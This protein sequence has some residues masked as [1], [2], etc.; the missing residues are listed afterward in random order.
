MSRSFTLSGFGSSADGNTALTIANSVV[1]SN[2]TSNVI[3]N[4]LSVAIGNSSVF[5][6]INATSYNG[7]ANNSLYLGGTAAASYVTTSTIGGLTANNTAYLGGLAASGY[8]T[9]AGLSA[10]VAT[11]AANNASYLGGVAAAS[12][13]NTSG[14]YTFTGIHSHNVGG[15]TIYMANTTSN[16]ISWGTGGVAAPAVTTKSAGTK[17]VLYDGIGSTS[18]DYAL[19]IEGSHL[20][21]STTNTATGFKWYANTTNIM[22]ANTTGLYMTG[23]LA[24]NSSGGALTANNSA[25][26]GG[27]AAASYVTTSTIG[28]L[29]ANNATY[30]NGV[31]SSGYIKRGGNIGNANLSAVASYSNTQVVGFDVAT[32]GPGVSYGSMLIMNERSDTSAQFVIDYASGHAYTRGILTSTP[33]LSAWNTL[34]D[35]NNYNSYSP[36]LTGTGASG[37]WGINITGNAATV[38]NGLTTSNYSSYALPL[39]GGTM[40]GTITSSASSIAIGTSGGATRGYL[41]NDTSGFGLLTS[42]GG[43]AVQVQYGTNTVYFPGYAYSAASLRAPIFYDQDNT[44]Y[45]VD[46]NNNTWLNVIGVNNYLYFTGISGAV[47][48]TS[49]PLHYADVTNHVIKPGSGNG[50]MLWQNYAGTTLAQNRLSDGYAFFP[51]IYDQNDTGYYVD[52]NGTANM[53]YV[54]ANAR[55]STGYD[56]GVT[57]SVSCNNWFRTSGGAGL[58]FASYGRGINPSDGVISYGNFCVYG[59][60]L[61]GWMGMGVT[62]DNKTNLMGNGTN[63]GVYNAAIGQWN[64]ILDNAGGSVT[65]QSNVTAYSDVRLKQNIRAIDDVLKRRNTLALAAIKYERDGRTRIGYA[66]QTL[67]DNGCAEFVRE[68]DD[69]LKVVTGL[70]T[71]SV[72]YGETAAVLAAASKMTDDRVEELEKRIAELEEIIRKLGASQ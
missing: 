32:N 36:T 56:S 28:G 61:N 7:T 71:L 30:F 24:I 46:G 35:N 58:Y 37:T 44:G 8:Q 26:L 42:S 54:Y 70:G 17:L 41:Y 9:T 1:V 21:F 12:Y 10:N 27:T 59:S 20:W 19:G 69:A 62:T 2:A 43:W 67:R 14:A 22:T 38:T 65:F 55:F 66:A 64:M 11:L 52:P 33:S 57:G 5:N 15:N 45:Y 48:T 72:D 18:V 31:A 6:S 63:W 13:A 34:L 4:P 47:N 40:T 53:Y 29:T 51:F 60:G 49:T 25:Y 68:A 16:W 50:T 3:V 39:S 23:T